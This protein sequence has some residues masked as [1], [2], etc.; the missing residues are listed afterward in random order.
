MTAAVAIFLMA[1]AVVV[2]AAVV[3]EVLVIRVPFLKATAC[4]WLR[5][6]SRLLLNGFSIRRAGR[7]WK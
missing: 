5:R 1:A 3:D 2:V 7:F 6:E 4:L